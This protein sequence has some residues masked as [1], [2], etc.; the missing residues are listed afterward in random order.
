VQLHDNGGT[1]NGGVDT[2]APQT[3]TITVTPVNDAPVA[4]DDAYQVAKNK[5]LSV[6]APGVLSNDSDVEHSPLTA[7]LVSGPAHGTLTLNSGTVTSP[8]Y[9]SFSYVIKP[10]S[11]EIQSNWPW[12]DS[13]IEGVDEVDSGSDRDRGAIIRQFSP[14]YNGS[15]TAEV[16]AASCR[17]DSKRL[18]AASTLP[19]NNF[20][21]LKIARIRQWRLD[22]VST[23]G[24]HKL[25]FGYGALDCEILVLLGPGRSQQLRLLGRLNPHRLP[26]HV[27]GGDLRAAELFKEQFRLSA[28]A[29]TR[30]AQQDEHHPH[31]QPLRPRILPRFRKPS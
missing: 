4:V 16:D 10:S 1:T 17:V 20:G 31:R 29:G 23:G 21:E 3:F 18:E 19:G 2:S 15:S 7:I 12:I 13:L 5:V 27:A 22:F 24:E 11:I 6:N 9:D 14:Y 30:R 26:Q 25:R 28:F 8:V